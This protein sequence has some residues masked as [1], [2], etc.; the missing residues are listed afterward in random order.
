MLSHVAR[1]EVAW[2]SSSGQPQSIASMTA[3][4]HIPPQPRLG[5]PIPRL[6]AFSCAHI[7]HSGTDNVGAAESSVGSTRPNSTHNPA[8][9]PSSHSLDM[10][11]LTS[12]ESQFGYAQPYLHKVTVWICT[13]PT[14]Q[15]RDTPNA[16]TRAATLQH[17][18]HADQAAAPRAAHCTQPEST[19]PHDG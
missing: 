3:W 17:T 8:L 7:H 11:S 6:P 9:P 13:A 18:P 10:P 19:A 12:I 5:G 15:A 16:A 4:Y 2:T 1:G 14:Q